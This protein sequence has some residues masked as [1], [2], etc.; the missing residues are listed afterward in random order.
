MRKKPV[1]YRAP[2]PPGRPPHEP[3]Q[4]DRETVKVMVAAGMLQPD[5]ARARGINVTT[6]AKHYREEL[7]TG[8]TQVDT[9]VVV[10]HL[11]AVKRGDFQAIRWWEQARMGWRGDT[12]EDGRAPDASMRVTVELVGEAAPATTIDHEPCSDDDAR[13]DLRKHVQLVG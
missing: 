11:K 8:K 1:R 10:E 7:D 12:S 2:N 9:G 3:T 6:L 4:V 13:A 5:I